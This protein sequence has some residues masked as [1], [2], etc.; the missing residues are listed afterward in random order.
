MTGRSAQPNAARKTSAATPIALHANLRSGLSGVH[1]LDTTGCASRAARLAD[2]ACQRA[3]LML[4]IGR[5]SGVEC[6]VT[7]I[8][9]VSAWAGGR[10]DFGS[11]RSLATTWNGDSRLV[12]FDR[13]VLDPERRI[14]RF[15]GVRHRRRFEELEREGELAHLRVLVDVAHD[16]VLQHVRAGLKRTRRIVFRDRRVLDG[17]AAAVEER[18]R[19]PVAKLLVRLARR[20]LLLLAAEPHH[21]QQAAEFAPRQR[22]QRLPLRPHP[23]GGEH[24]DG[25]RER[26]RVVDGERGRAV[27]RK[28]E[29]RGARDDAGRHLDRERHG[30]DVGPAVAAM[31]AVG[32]GETHDG[33]VDAGHGEDAP[34]E[35][36]GLRRVA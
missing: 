28:I 33:R 12:P 19:A 11:S 26:M 10:T 25:H 5:E 2:S 1:A 3:R 16:L 32:I 27:Q 29:T 9:K 15:P 14:L 24:P 22:P 21:A 8:E 20:A 7:S 13:G 31:A 30:P 34:R 4:P 35:P 18:H 17:V 6:S 23:L 36:F